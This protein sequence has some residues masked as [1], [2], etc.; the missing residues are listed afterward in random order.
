MKNKILITVELLTGC[1]CTSFLVRGIS[2]L[3]LQKNTPNMSSFQKHLNYL[4]CIGSQYNKLPT[5]NHFILSCIILHQPNFFW[6]NLSDGDSL[7]L[8][9]LYATQK[10]TFSI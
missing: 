7:H 2:C 9:C 4:N 5:I 3:Q 1:T 10:T 6:K 8:L